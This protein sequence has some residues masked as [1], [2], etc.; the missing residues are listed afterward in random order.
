MISV[1]EVRTDDESIAWDHYVLNHSLASGYQ[2]IGWRRVVQRAFGHR[3]YYLMAR[4][5]HGQVLG[6]LP[7]VFV[8]SRLFGRTLV[9]M[10]FVNYGGVLADHVDAQR[11]LLEAAASR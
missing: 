5:E 1:S 11:A 4:D 9:S 3:T 8:A 7:L 10:P 2:L 6:V